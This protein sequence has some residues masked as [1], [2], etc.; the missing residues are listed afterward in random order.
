MKLDMHEGRRGIERNKLPS[1]Q[2][3]R[4]AVELDLASKYADKQPYILYTFCLL[5]QD[6]ARLVCCNLAEEIAYDE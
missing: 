4:Y 5:G 2:K 3:D 1:S 6:F